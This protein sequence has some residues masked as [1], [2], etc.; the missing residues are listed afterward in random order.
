MKIA[1][2]TSC[3]F[4]SKPEKS[5]LHLPWTEYNAPIISIFLASFIYDRAYITH[6][7]R[8]TE[9][10]I[11]YKYMELKDTWSACVGWWKF[12]IFVC[13]ICSPMNQYFSSLTMVPE[14]ILGVLKASW[15][16]GNTIICPLLLL[17]CFS[18][19]LCLTAAVLQSVFS[20]SF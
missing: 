11:F 20:Q 5:P 4:L 2:T 10:R 18:S 14:A 3:F 16:L 7:E 12:L 17:N 19:E 9:N 8:W 1:T 6:Q 15:V 13:A